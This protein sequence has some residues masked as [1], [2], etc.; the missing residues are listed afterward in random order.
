M[1]K[2]ESVPRDH[3]MSEIRTRIYAVIAAIPQ[4]RV[5]TYGQVAAMAGVPRHARQ[6]GY[7]LFDLPEGSPLPW[8][9]VVNA[10]GE[11][12]QRREPGCGEV[13]RTKLEAEGIAFRKGRVDLELYRWEPGIARRHDPRDAWE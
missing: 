3:P 1:L 8:H 7:A 2:D 11:I 4:G 5:V 10:R 12:S 6:V 13:Q 9:R